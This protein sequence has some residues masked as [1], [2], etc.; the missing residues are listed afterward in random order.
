M[1]TSKAELVVGIFADS[2]HIKD[3][4]KGMC[5]YPAAGLHAN[6]HQESFIPSSSTAL[7]PPFDPSIVTSSTLPYQQ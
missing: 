4:I 1:D 5:A 2:A 3:M 6:I 7:S